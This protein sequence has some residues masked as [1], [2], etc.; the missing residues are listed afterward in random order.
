M[1]FNFSFHF[2][3]VVNLIW[4][5]LYLFI[6]I[7]LFECILIFSFFNLLFWCN[8]F[9]FYFLMYFIFWSLI[10]LF[11]NVFY[12]LFSFLIYF[13]FSYFLY[14]SSFSKY[15]ENEPTMIWFHFLITIVDILWDPV[16]FCPSTPD[17]RILTQIKKWIKEQGR[18]GSSL[19]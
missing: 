15:Q 8:L 1:D 17:F 14:L 12:F 5:V 4:N 6:F 2:L 18:L 7:L 19:I 3:N 10:L 11:F 13:I 16:A 9:L